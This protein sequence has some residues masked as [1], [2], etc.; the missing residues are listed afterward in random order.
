VVM[1]WCGGVLVCWRSGAV[2]GVWCGVVWLCGV[3]VWCGVAG[4]GVPANG[5]WK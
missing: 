1:W 2:R 5:L 4:E 3:V